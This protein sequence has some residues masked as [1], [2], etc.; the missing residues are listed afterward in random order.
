MNLHYQW[1]RT[2]GLFMIATMTAIGALQAQTGM[3]GLIQ[4]TRQLVGQDCMQSHQAVLRNQEI[5]PDSAAIFDGATNRQKSST[6]MHEYDEQGNTTLIETLDYDND[7]RGRLETKFGYYTTYHGIQYYS[8]I[9][10]NTALVWENGK[11]IVST[12][13]KYT[14]DAIGKLTGITQNA[15]TPEPVTI[16]Y[17]VTT[18]ANT[19]DQIVSEEHTIDPMTFPSLKDTYEYGTNGKIAVWTKSAGMLPYLVMS[20]ITTKYTYN[21]KDLETE[22]EIT[23]EDHVTGTVLKRKEVFTYDES[24]R[25]VRLDI[26]EDESGGYKLFEYV[27]YYYGSITGMTFPNIPGKVKVASGNGSITIE[28][29]AVISSIEIYAVS[30]RL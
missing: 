20:T 4:K 3:N 11:F 9:L 6:I 2:A 18:E 19:R 30:G 7:L 1:K 16:K 10:E 24:D 13:I 17:S 14:Y 27:I 23:T 21:S 26:Y 28:S 5:R 15:F 12:E 22:K 8:R 29:D 25:P